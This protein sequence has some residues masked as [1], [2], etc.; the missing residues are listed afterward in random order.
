MSIEI[1]DLCRRLFAMQA[2]CLLPLNGP[3]Y[4]GDPLYVIHSL[5]K[6]TIL[7]ALPT[8]FQSELIEL[9]NFKRTDLLIQSDNSLTSIFI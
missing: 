1:L 5:L 9:E 4:L 8:A 3:Q 2:E 6:D 7:E